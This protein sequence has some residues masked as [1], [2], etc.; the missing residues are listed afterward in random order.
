MASGD[1]AGMTIG[2]EARV[3]LWRGGGKQAGAGFEPATN[4][5]AIRPIG[6]LW[7]P[8][9]GYNIV[10]GGGKKIQGLLDVVL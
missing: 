8:A 9:V 7:H 4:G 6:P 2:Q 10:A 5:F 1:C 3:R